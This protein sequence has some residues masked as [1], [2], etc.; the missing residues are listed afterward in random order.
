[1]KF[2]QLTVTTIAACLIMQAPVR[3][4]FVVTDPGNTYQAAITAGATILNYA[5]TAQMLEQTIAM[6]GMFTT[7]FAVTGLLSQL[8]QGNKYPSTNKLSEQMFDSQRPVSATARAIATDRDRAVD[9]SDAHAELLRGQITGAANAASVAA[10]NLELM[11][12]RL[13]ENG[14]TLG[15][16]S[17]SRNIMQAT[18]TN[19]LLLKQVHDA[20]IQNSQ[21]TSLLTMATAQASL[22]AAEEAAAQR[23][24]R[25][26]TAKIFSPGL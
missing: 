9:G 1:M 22:H 10:D 14:N 23:R 7:T 4:Q 5:K 8:N 19:G 18:V 3:A 21:A 17:R 25:L 26:E 20:I 24:E 15:Q 13:R 2:T 12:K 16:L 6:V 11:D